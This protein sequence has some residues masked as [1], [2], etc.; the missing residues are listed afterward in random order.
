MVTLGPDTSFNSNPSSCWSE[1]CS[2]RSARANWHAGRISFSGLNARHINVR[3]EGEIGESFNR[4]KPSADSSYEGRS[5]SAVAHDPCE[6][7]ALEYGSACDVFAQSS[8]NA[9][10]HHQPSPFNI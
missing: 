2:S 8:W 3:F 6:A 7:N 4:V 1:T 5:L 10:V 9:N